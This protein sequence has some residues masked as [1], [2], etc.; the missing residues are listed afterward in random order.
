MKWLT[1]VCVTIC[2]VA[3]GA[4]NPFLGYWALTIP[5][6][7]AACAELQI[8]TVNAFTLTGG[9]LTLSGGLTDSAA[10][11]GAV[12][13]T[14][15]CQVTLGAASTWDIQSANTTIDLTGVLAASVNTYSLTKSGSGILILGNSGNTW[16][17]STT[18]G[19]GLILNAGTVQIAAIGCLGNSNNDVTFGGGTLQV[20]GNCTAAAGNGFD[21]AGSS[22]TISVDDGITLTLGQSGNLR[23]AAGGLCILNGAGTV[24]LGG[25]NS[26]T[27][28][29]AVLRADAGIV[30]LR[31]SSNV[32]GGTSN[33]GTLRLNGGLARIYADSAFTFSCNLN[34]IDL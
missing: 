5:G 10:P 24:D 30:Q 13:R 28:V 9:I 18:N 27:F 3:Q 19:V 15:A 33:R 20:T 6:G 8:T 31:T 26:T 14:I 22:G 25:D 34:G 23:G 21:V 11:G 17:G 2:G 4:E 7:G 1:C 12:T 32:I 16:G 29:S